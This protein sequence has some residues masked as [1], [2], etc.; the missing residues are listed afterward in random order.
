MRT[1]CAEVVALDST[2]VRDFFPGSPMPIDQP[3]IVL[4]GGGTGGHL[5]PGLAVAR[6]L[7]ALRPGMRITFAG[8]GKPWERAE[9]ARAGFD[10][11]ALRCCPRPSRIA[12]VWR[13]LADNLAGYEAARRFLQHA[14]VDLVVGLGGYTSAPMA[15]AAAA[16]GVPLVLL[17]Q[18]AIPGRVT[19][20]L[21]RRADIVCTS[22]ESTA[23][24]LPRRCPVRLTGNPVWLRPS[25]GSAT[26]P[27]PG[28]FRPRLLV[29]GGSGGSGSLNRAVPDALARTASR[30][31]GWRILHQTGRG[32]VEPVRVR[33]AKLG[34]HAE[35][36]EFL[37]DVPGELADADLAVCRAGG[38][39][40]AEL[41]AAGVPAV[42]VPFPRAADDHQGRNAQAF[43]A[44]GACLIVDEQDNAASLPERLAT[45]LAGPL[46]GTVRRAAMSAAIR[47]LSRPR[48]AD[49]V[50][51]I[52]L[53]RL[54]KREVRANVRPAA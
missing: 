51:A 31:R 47:R 1:P 25:L 24:Y 45:A 49:E 8:G 30:M 19:R 17:E 53:D 33:Y 42:V 50:A 37:F 10:Y 20:W 52:V 12:G 54:G 43:A 18:N 5:F 46:S 21:A 39:T 14:G 6:K 40:L 26:T 3:H 36:A 22:L 7:V 4:S 16:R 28:G 32:E 15:R 29:L 13:F 35:V 27:L 41:A 11:V 23:G 44:G 34:L 2:H 38:T 9:V 48:A